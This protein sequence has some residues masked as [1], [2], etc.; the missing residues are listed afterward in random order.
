MRD[1]IMQD[2]LH[3]TDGNYVHRI[4]EAVTARDK[5]W[6]RW[7]M[8]ACPPIE[9]PRVS[10]AAFDEARASA[11]RMMTSKKLRPKPMGSLNL[12][13]LENDD[14]EMAMASF[15][16]PGR[17]KLPEL[18][19]FKAK[20]AEDD[21]ELD[22]AKTE[23]EKSQMLEQKASKT[24]RAL[25]IA[26]RNRLAAFDKIDNW[27]KIDPVFEDPADLVEPE[28]AQDEGETGRKPEDK[29]PLIIAGPAGAAAAAL[30]SLLMQRQPNVF[31]RLLQHTTRQPKN[32]EANGT[33][34]HFVDSASFNVLQDGDQFL[35]C[36]NVDGTDYGTSRKTADSIAEAG[37]V[38]LMVFDRDVSL[39]TSM[40]TKN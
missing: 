34:F 31:T 19:K 18:A 10:A 9:R 35:E 21:F 17:Y 4:I 11:K 2:I 26:S 8:E 32:G 28:E 36:H 40:L 16:D 37:K 13:F 15:K 25:R 27:Q 14:P 22:F 38:P 29:T 6:V 7:K 39:N 24:W 23:K 5:G 33:D 20:I 12:D 3:T 1:K 30:A